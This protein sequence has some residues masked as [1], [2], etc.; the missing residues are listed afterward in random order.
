LRSLCP[1][2]KLKW[3]NDL[4][5]ETDS[6]DGWNK[7][8]GILVELTDK[9]PG[10]TV[11]HTGIGL[12]IQPTAAVAGVNGTSL[13]ELGAPYAAGQVAEL[14]AQLAHGVAAAA[15]K[16]LTLGLGAIVAEFEGRAALI[17]KKV[18]VLVGSNTVSGC[19]V[20]IGKD[21]SLLVRDES[22]DVRSYVEGEVTMRPPLTPEDYDRK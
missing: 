16:L 8:G 7:L 22:G 3:P 13:I 15:H 17:G 14:T 9:S 10:T 4:I 6:A 2:V 21:G 1:Q 19:M 12:N 5:V 20:G 18:T 11:V